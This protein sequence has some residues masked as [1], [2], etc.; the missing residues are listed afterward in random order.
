[1]STDIPSFRS[2]VTDEMKNAAA[3]A[4]QNEKFIFGESVFK[5]EEECGSGI[6][7]D[8]FLNRFFF[9]ID[10]TS[11]KRAFLMLYGGSAKAVNLDYD[12]WPN[13][14]DPQVLEAT[15]L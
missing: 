1:M 14:D 2:E 8:F 13:S 15:I 7:R 5:F 11:V 6:T 4:L 9:P 10:T 3:E 12:A